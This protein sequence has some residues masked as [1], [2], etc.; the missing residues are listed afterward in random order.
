MTVE[1]RDNVA[2]RR[3]SPLNVK[4]KTETAIRHK[5]KDRHVKTQ[6]MVIIS[7]D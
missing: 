5:V 2:F 3:I 7:L 1:P 4:W 6:T